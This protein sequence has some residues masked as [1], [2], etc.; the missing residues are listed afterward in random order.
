METVKKVAVPTPP[1][2]VEAIANRVEGLRA[3]EVAWIE[4]VAKG[5]VLPTPTE[6]VFI[7]LKSVESKRPP[8][9]VEATANS[10]VK[11]VAVDVA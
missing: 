10:V 4:K 1:A 7:T 2:D 8:A 11:L 3:V 9:L 5:E 6:P